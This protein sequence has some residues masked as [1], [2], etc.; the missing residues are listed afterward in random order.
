MVHA[1]NKGRIDVV[2]SLLRRGARATPTTS[3]QP[4]A[5]YEACAFW[6]RAT[7]HEQQRAKEL[8]DL[9][10][11]HRADPFAANYAPIT[12]LS[13][14]TRER[15]EFLNILLCHAVTQNNLP[16]TQRLL[17]ARADVNRVHSRRGMTPLSIACLEGHRDMV[18]LLLDRGA[19]VDPVDN[20]PLY[21]VLADERFEIAELLIRRGANPARLVRFSF[22]AGRSLVGE[23]LLLDN[24]NGAAFLVQRFQ[25]RLP[26]ADVRA[27]YSTLFP[28]RRTVPDDY[29]PPDW[30]PN[31]PS[32]LTPPTGTTETIDATATGNA[33][34]SL[35]SD[36]S[37]QDILRVLLR[38]PRFTRAWERAGR[39]TLEEVGDE[40][41]IVDGVSVFPRGWGAQCDCTSNKIQI[42]RDARLFYKIQV[43]IFETMN[44]VQKENFLLLDRRRASGQLG[45]EEYTQLT[46]RIEYN[47]EI[48]T[49]EIH[50]SLGLT[51][52][53]IRN[54]SQV[55]GDVQKT[56][57]G[58]HLS[59]ADSYRSIWDNENGRRFLATKGDEVRK[60]ADELRA[61]RRFGSPGK[62]PHG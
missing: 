48:W 56:H 11:E 44:L 21:G 22:G 39:P 12:P 37:L 32:P 57:E 55:W 58:A 16:L 30:L 47:S 23:L 35:R 14:V 52:A 59:H 53:P 8:I 38:D 33:L 46:E 51:D 40:A 31:I 4:T 29:R 54:F 62:A 18:S 25:D 9:L 13:L 20:N 5:F 50:H 61:R 60:R 24:L 19:E 41:F 15:E 7:S 2:S 3:N 10:M 34:R 43:L 26:E 49:R 42:N 45:R 6:Q 17:D 36:A 1:T 27:F 28:P